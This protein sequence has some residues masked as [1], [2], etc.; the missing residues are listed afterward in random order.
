MSVLRGMGVSP[1]IATGPVVR[2]PEAVS[3]PPDLPQP[4]DRDR[5]AA[6]I[7]AAAA[8]VSADL[9]ARAQRAR[10][11][12]REVLLAVAA[13]ASD[14]ALLASAEQRVLADGLPAARATWEAA[15][16]V[17]HRLRAAGDYVA[18]RASDVE[19]IRNRLVAAL[20]DLPMP[21]IPDP[22]H[23]FILVAR[24]LSPADTATL[25]RSHVLAF[26]T[27]EGGPTSHTAII[28]RALGLPAV[29]A[30]A[31]A[32]GLDDG[33]SVTVDGTSGRVTIPTAGSSAPAIT[34]VVESATKAWSGSGATADRRLVPLLA[35]VGSVDDVDA[36]IRAGA[37]G[38]GL[39]RT[40]LLFLDR[41]TE[42]T[43]E[44]Q[45]ELYEQIFAAFPDKQVVVRTLDAG[46]DRPLRFLGASDEPNPALG[47]RGLRISLPERHLLERQLTAVSAAAHGSQADV[48]VMGP[49]VSVPAEAAQFATAVRSTGLTEV[50]VMI[51][52]PAAALAAAEV[53]AEVD[54]ISVGTN[55][56]TQYTMAADRNSGPLA[57]LND[58]WQPAVLRLV[59]M[60]AQ[61]A[62]AA[63]KP[64][65]V[66]GEAAAD[67]LL[68][69]VL[70]GLGI[71]SLSMA[72]RAIPAVGELL[73][74]T[75][76]SDCIRLAELATKA[77]DASTAREA[78]RAALP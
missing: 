47:L 43:V 46:A 59:Q 66:C 53:L 29:A 24:D 72:P 5:E 28:A 60:C 17:A 9:Q 10:G 7:A 4:A 39:L 73:R 70:V 32:M 41:V 61:A 30:C 16:D 23:P 67:P 3:K 68:A 58:P 63:G 13:M 12:P 25:D 45:R 38:I 49:M 54:F 78:V 22:G 69:A 55:D 33:M 26:V 77:P 35:N 27:V 20:L 56:L 31:D 15:T 64:V 18:A 44:E 8:S 51:E 74:R 36:A 37:E 50:G 11:E 76:Y 62:M 6:R 2:L 71:S 52:V 14:P 42:P 40:E 65:G 75:S 1:G 34:A 57:A 21:D 48:W 19:D